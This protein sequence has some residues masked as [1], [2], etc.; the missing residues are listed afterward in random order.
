MVQQHGGYDAVAQENQDRC[1][2]RL[3]S[4]DA[5]TD[6]SP[7]KPQNRD[8]GANPGA[9]LIAGEDASQRTGSRVFA[10]GVERS[11]RR[12]ERCGPERF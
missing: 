2:D 4:D 7:R 10:A 9:T 8:S 3:C 11:F 1:P 6:S 5:Q 12:E